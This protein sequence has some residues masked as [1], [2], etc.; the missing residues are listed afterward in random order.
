[1]EPIN[2]FAFNVAKEIAIAC[3]SGTNLRIDK[4]NGECVADFFE[5]IYNKALKLSQDAE[6]K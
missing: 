4:E 2:H 1:M 3:L 6:V 5:A